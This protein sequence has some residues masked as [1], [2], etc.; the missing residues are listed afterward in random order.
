MTKDPSG[1]KSRKYSYQCLYEEEGWIEAMS[2]SLRA[3]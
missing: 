2:L 3:A 1:L